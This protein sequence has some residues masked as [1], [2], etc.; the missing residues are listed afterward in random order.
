MKM[1]HEFFAAGNKF[2]DLAGKQIGLDR[3]NAVTLYSLNFIQLVY[4]IKE[5]FFVLFVTIETFSEVTE[6]Y[7][8]Q[9]NF[10]YISLS[11]I[12]CVPDNIFNCIAPAF[13]T[14]HWNGA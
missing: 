5:I 3:R 11:N 4:K 2:D 1:R 12:F 8:R 7:T 6:V 9:Y 10:F 14:R 13:S